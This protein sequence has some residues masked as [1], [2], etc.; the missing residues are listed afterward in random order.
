LATI[1][2]IVMNIMVWK[3]VKHNIDVQK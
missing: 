1:T 2:L 3:A